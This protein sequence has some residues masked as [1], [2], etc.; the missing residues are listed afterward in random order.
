MPVLVGVGFEAQNRHG[1][2]SKAQWR[3]LLAFL[4][5]A[6]PF[7]TV[8]EATVARRRSHAAIWIRERREGVGEAVGTTWP[9][10]LPVAIHTEAGLGKRNPG[11][12]ALPGAAHDPFTSYEEVGRYAPSRRRTTERPSRV[13]TATGWQSH[14]EDWRGRGPIDERASCTSSVEP[15]P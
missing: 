5:Q 9:A 7:K 1:G 15:L 8:S 3:S 10:T 13:K 12:V 4:D 2:M 6:V 14:S 11:A